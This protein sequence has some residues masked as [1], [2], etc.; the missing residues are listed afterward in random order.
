MA[1]YINING[2]NIPIRASDPS[3]PI[4]GEVWYNTTDNALKGQGFQ[5]AAWA[6]GGAYPQNIGTIST[7]GAG[8]QTAGLMVGGYVGPNPIPAGGGRTSFVGEYDGSSWSSGGSWPTFTDAGGIGGTQTAAITAGE[9]RNDGS[10]YYYTT[11]LDYNGSTWTSNNPI[12]AAASTVSVLGTQTAAIGAGGQLD[13][14]YPARFAYTKTMDWDG[15][16]WA[17]TGGTMSNARI[18]NARAGTAGA[19]MMIAGQEYAVGAS[20]SGKLTAVEN[21]DGTSWTSGPAVNTARSGLAGG[22]TQSLAYIAGGTIPG[23]T[24]ATEEYD[25]SS[26]TNSTNM[27][28]AM[29][30]S[31][32]AVSTRAAGWACGGG[33]LKAMEEF[34]GSSAS[35]LTIS[36]S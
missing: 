27:S 22:G 20:P 36:S 15:T 26:W 25:G 10:I 9:F 12:P 17:D 21:Y 35:T 33:P 7:I 24:A 1:D 19:A 28:N 29:Q 2:N 11:S 32:G 5:T 6:T 8:T 4:L 3:N 31:S 14:P 13:E 18:S 34:T 30:C 16:S 23:N